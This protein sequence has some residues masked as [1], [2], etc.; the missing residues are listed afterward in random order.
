MENLRILDIFPKR[1]S[2]KEAR[3]QRKKVAKIFY[4]LF[5]IGTSRFGTKGKGPFSSHTVQCVLSSVSS[6]FP[7]KG[8]LFFSPKLIDSY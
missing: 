6:A 8:N 7:R 3:I 2:L 4:F 5:Q 1:I